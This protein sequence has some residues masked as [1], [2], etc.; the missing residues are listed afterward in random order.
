MERVLLSS[1]LAV[2]IFAGFSAGISIG[3]V[4]IGFSFAGLCEAL[5]GV[6]ESQEEEDEY[7]G[8]E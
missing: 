5:F 3:S 2:I 7:L 6:K 8:D 4:Y 1:L